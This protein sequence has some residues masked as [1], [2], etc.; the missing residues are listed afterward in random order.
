MRGG[1]RVILHT[2]GVCLRLRAFA[3]AVLLRPKQQIPAGFILALLSRPSGSLL[4]PLLVGFSLYLYLHLTLSVSH[5]SFA[6]SLPLVKRPPGEGRPL[7][8]V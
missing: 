8:P 1:L 2:S 3:R 7:S 5:S 6:V 4:C